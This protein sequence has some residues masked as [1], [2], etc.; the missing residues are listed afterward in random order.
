MPRKVL[1][2]FFPLILAFSTAPILPAEPA[3][4]REALEQGIRLMGQEDYDQA[5]LSF[6]GLLL[7]AAAEGLK[8]DASFW[9]AKAY[10]ASGKLEE[11]ARS[12]E[13]FLS[14]YPGH[15][16]QPEAAYLK[17]RLLFLQGDH[18]SAILALKAFIQRHPGAEYV[19]HAY[20]W[21]GESLY[22][23]G[24]LDEAAR[25]YGKVLDDYPRSFKVEAAGYRLS[26][27]DFKRR[28][29]ELLKLLKWSHE[30]SLR[31][32]EEF[33]KREKTYEQALVAYQRRLQDQK[34]QEGGQA[35]AAAPV[36]ELQTLQAENAALIS[37]L[38][39]LEARLG[40]VSPS[41]PLSAGTRLELA[42]LKQEALDLKQRLLGRLEAYAGSR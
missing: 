26:L 15:S 29:N 32:T 27:V 30:E 33:Q 42:K 3:A 6:R 40:S 7:D 12:L 24:H 28:E 2:A 25:M 20:F 1:C 16:S 37:R 4:G 22:T 39:A 13:F 21:I 23:L 31:T 36:A 5:I 19:P 34:R 11:S 14:G 9:L 17:G 10:L 38:E 41:E 35:P 18:E 8:P